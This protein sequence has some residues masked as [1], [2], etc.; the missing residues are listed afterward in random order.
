MVDILSILFFVLLAGTKLLLAPGL[1]LAA[2]YGL[3]KTILITYIGALFGAIVFYYFGVAIFSWLDELMG[4]STKKKIVFSKKARAMVKVKI[5]YGIIGIASLAPII[6]IPI[7]ALIV[8][9]FFPGKHA[10]IGV[11]AVVLIPIAILLTLI[12]EPVIQPIIG[13][14]KAIFEEN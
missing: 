10:V 13:L 11:Y 2:G 4:T 8:A 3:I 6:S 9:K 1:M 14:M 5:R 7:S 12:S